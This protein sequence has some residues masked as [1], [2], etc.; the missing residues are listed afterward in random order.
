MTGVK[1]A[2]ANGQREESDPITML[3]GCGRIS[4]QKLNSNGV[5][6]YRQLIAFK[7]DIPGVNVGALKNTA[8]ADLKPTKSTVEIQNHNWKD[9]VCHLVREKGQV[10]RAIIGNLVVGPHRVLLDVKWTARGKRR[11]KAISPVAL[12]CAQILWL[13]NDIISD[14][15]DSDSG[16]SLQSVLPKFLVDTTSTVIQNLSRSELVAIHSVVK[17]TN[18]LYNCLNGTDP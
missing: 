17:E 4:S 15:S 9:R 12:L 10:T 5:F 1:A 3:K 16:E 6:T 2:R 8:L 7:G 11:T 14:D 18:Q 13:S